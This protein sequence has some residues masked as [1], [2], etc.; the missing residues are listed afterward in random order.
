MLPESLTVPDEAC[1]GLSYKNRW[2]LRVSDPETVALAAFR[3]PLETER[4]AA[5][6]LNLD[7]QLNYRDGKKFMAW[8][9]AQEYL[10]VE[11]VAASG[12]PSQRK[13]QKVAGPRPNMDRPSPTTAQPQALKAET[14]AENLNP[15][16]APH[17]LWHPTPNLTSHSSPRL[18]LPA[19]DSAHIS[20]KAPPA[21][22]AACALPHS[23]DTARRPL[24]S[25]PPH[26]LHVHVG[27]LETVERVLDTESELKSAFVCRQFL[28]DPADVKARNGIDLDLEVQL[29]GVW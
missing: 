29:V 6:D 7:R 14:L 15:A 22:A 5:E 25:R 28:P 2:V 1:R 23:C 10:D 12:R 24:I 21:R 11:R 17:N 27:Y 19:S 13:G 20:P 18:L 16:D 9:L 8:L 4:K 3:I 26:R